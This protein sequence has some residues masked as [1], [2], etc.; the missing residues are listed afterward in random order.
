MVVADLDLG[1]LGKFHEQQ[2]VTAS[3]DAAADESDEYD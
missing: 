3:I 2:S 1:P